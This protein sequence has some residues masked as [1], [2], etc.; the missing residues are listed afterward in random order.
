MIGFWLDSFQTIVIV[1]IAWRVHV[2]YEE[3]RY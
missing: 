2:L 3:M 1:W